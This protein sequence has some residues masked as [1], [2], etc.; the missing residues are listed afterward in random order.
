[1]TTLDEA[2]AK[3]HDRYFKNSHWKS[4]YN[5]APSDAKKY[6]DLIFSQLDGGDDKENEEAFKA[7]LSSAYREMSEEGW[8]YLIDNT[9]SQMEK[10]HL[11]QKKA[12]VKN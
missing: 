10:N 5:E 2:I 4:L 7:R 6:Y 11:K 12:S 3:G 1:M 8:K 9:T